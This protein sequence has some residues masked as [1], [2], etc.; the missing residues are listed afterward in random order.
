MKFFLIAIVL[1]IP[2][3]AFSQVTVGGLMDLEFRMS[4]SDSKP[5]I[6]GSPST[7]PSIY[8][9]NIRL[10]FDAPI[11]ENWSVLAVVQSDHYGSNTLNAPFFSLLQ[12]QWFPFDDSD[13]TMNI[14]RIVIPVGLTSERFL[15]NENPLR[16]LPMN[17]EWTQRVDKKAG[18]LT[19]PRNY[20]TAP[21]LAFIYNRMYTQGISVQGDITDFAEY[22]LAAALAAPSGFNESGEYDMPAIMGRVVVKPAVWMRLGGSFGHGGYMR[23]DAMN[24]PLS[25][26]DRA[27]LKQTILGVDASVDYR[28]VRLSYEYLDTRWDVATITLPGSFVTSDYL[29]NSHMVEMKADAPFHPGAYVALR[30]ERMMV[31]SPVFNA[32]PLQRLEVGIGKKISRSIIAKATF[33]KGWDEG[34]DL[35]DN[36]FGVQLS[37]GF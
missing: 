25:D 10:F 4:G 33:A 37:V 3:P 28:Y 35:E 13:F 27:S 1:F 5:Y 24:A 11:S 2:T 34:S 6:N 30:Y 21:G 8:V 15:S 32:S 26:D 19:G 9:P 22:H 17:M 18:L 7:K 16:H 31:D 23:K 36:V 12:A 14:G 20:A 29:A